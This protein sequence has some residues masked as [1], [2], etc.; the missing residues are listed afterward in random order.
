MTSAPDSPQGTEPTAAGAGLPVYLDMPLGAFLAELGAGR[1]PPAGGCAAAACVALS[2]SLCAM[3][4]RL[5]R[6]QL[7]SSLAAELTAEAQRLS[8]S[9]GAQIQADAE[10]VRQALTADAAVMPA[11]AA[12]VPVQTLEL[13]VQVMRL[14]AR[15]A[16]DGNQ[17]LHGDAICALLLAGAGARA[18]AVLAEIDLAGAAPGDQLTRHVRELRQDAIGLAERVA[19]S[20]DTKPDPVAE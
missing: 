17:N 12:S 18:T 5:S 15:L 6:R 4:A 9:A 10:A 8:A 20:Y 3:T 1:A 2:A 13:A 14:A 19:G 11:E 7:G 16:A